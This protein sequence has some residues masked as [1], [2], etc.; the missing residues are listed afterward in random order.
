MIFKRYFGSKNP[1]LFLHYFENLHYFADRPVWMDD[2]SR[3]RNLLTSANALT[4]FVDSVSKN[5]D[6]AFFEHLR[7]SDGFLSAIFGI[8][9]KFWI[10]MRKKLS[11]YFFF[12]IEKNLKKSLKKKFGR[13]FEKCPKF[14]KFLKD[15]SKKLIF[16]K[17]TF[18]KNP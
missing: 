11:K 16:S 4:K 2:Q 7:S 18:L 13:F 9:G 12:E 10:D 3:M 17:S 1:K 5:L 14:S 6:F 8:F 15:F